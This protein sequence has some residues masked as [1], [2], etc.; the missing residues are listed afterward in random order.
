MRKTIFVKSGANLAALLQAFPT[1]TVRDVASNPG[2]DCWA[3]DLTVEPEPPPIFPRMSG[4]VLVVK[5]GDT[6]IDPETAR[7]L[8]QLYD[9]NRKPQPAFEPPKREGV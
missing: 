5:E 8:R 3:V 2:E 4:V 9:G 7:F 1:A 6:G